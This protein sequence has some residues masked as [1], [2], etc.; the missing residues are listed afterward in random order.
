MKALCRE[1]KRRSTAFLTRA[2]GAFCC[3][4]AFSLT[5]AHAAKTSIESGTTWL[6]NN[7]DPVNAHG[8]GIWVESA[9]DKGSTFHVWLPRGKQ[10]DVSRTS[11][12]MTVP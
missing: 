8:G 6:D 5:S 1:R 7:G 2:L 3:L 9:P 11:D 4:A 10:K 12:H